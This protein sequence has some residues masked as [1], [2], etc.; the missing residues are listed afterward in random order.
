MG[1]EAG[2]Q[3]AARGEA[4]KTQAERRGPRWVEGDQGSQQA[5]RGRQG[6][7]VAGGAEAAGEGSGRCARRDS[8]ELIAREE[9]ERGDEKK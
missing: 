9:R 7:E 6:G 8:R 3:G 1:E 4:H 2:E 5:T